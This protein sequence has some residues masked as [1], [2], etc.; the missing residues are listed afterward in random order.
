MDGDKK[1]DDE[2]ER[3]QNSQYMCNVVLMRDDM[4][5]PDDI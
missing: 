1:E 3:E 4:Q 2:N 5:E